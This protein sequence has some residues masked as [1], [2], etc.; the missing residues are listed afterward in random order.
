MAY[1]FLRLRKAPALV[2]ECPGIVQWRQMPVRGAVREVRGVSK[3]CQG[4]PGF[5]PGRRTLPTALGNAFRNFKR[6]R[7][8]ACPGGTCESSPAL[9]RWEPGVGGLSPGGTVE[10]CWRVTRLSRPSGT[11]VNALQTQR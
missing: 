1:A 6:L 10:A 9:Q 2:G 5:I 4:L 8:K 11:R 7:E 3:P